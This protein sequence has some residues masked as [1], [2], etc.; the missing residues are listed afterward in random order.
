MDQEVIKSLL[1]VL[2]FEKIA[3]SI[4]LLLFTWLMLYGI[5]HLSHL[6]AEKFPR[7]RL[8]ISSIFPVFRLLAWVHIVAFI[9][10]KILRPPGE[11]IML[12]AGASG[13]AI[14][15]GAQ[16]LIKNILAG[17]L[18]L[19]ERPF[20]VGDM[21]KVENYYGEVTN[22]GL[23]ASRLHTFD[24][25]IVTLPNSMLL[26]SG[27]SNSNTG[28]LHELV[29]VTFFL[30]ATVN[31]DKVKTLAHEAALCSP[32]VHR[33]QTVNVLV[34]DEF[35][36]A[37]LTVFTIQAYTIDVRFER[38]LASD[39]TERVKEEVNKRGLLRKEAVA[40]ALSS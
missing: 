19:F 11:T 4:A 7:R 25:S 34:K 38:L 20:R 28:S 40:E 6:L 33:G 14:G 24:D 31:A 21:I 3:L 17:I 5:K 35:E 36:R 37:F 23:R 10:M 12:V 18:I 32:Y 15:L 16:D 9:I 27:V 30:P 26:N 13:V 1:E 2:N 8:L 39:L 29:E 22:V